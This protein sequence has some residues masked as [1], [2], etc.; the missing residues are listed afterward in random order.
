[1]VCD[2]KQQDVSLHVEIVF[3]FQSS[4][5]ILQPS[6]VKFSLELCGNVSVCMCVARCQF[7]WVGVVLFPV[8]VLWG[9]AMSQNEGRHWRVVV[10][11]GRQGGGQFESR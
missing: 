3:L 9:A 4:M 7:A 8:V 11:M 6:R 2:K 10:I 1:M 5:E